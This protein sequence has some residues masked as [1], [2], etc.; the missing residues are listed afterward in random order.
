MQKIPNMMD[1]LIGRDGFHLLQG[2]CAEHGESRYPAMERIKQWK[3]PECAIRETQKQEAEEQR[4]ARISSLLKISN[5][6]ER[7]RATRFEC[8]T[9]RQKQAKAG[10]KIFFDAVVSGE[11]KWRVLL[12]LGEAGTGKT[13]LASSIGENVVQMTA[14]QVRYTTAME[15]MADIRETYSQIDKSEREVIDRFGS[16]PL[17]IIDEID[18]LRE[19]D[20]R[21]MGEIINK[22]YNHMLPT[23]A[24]SNRN[25]QD[26]KIILGDRVDSRFDENCHMIIFDWESFRK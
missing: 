26:L 23:I 8:H 5:I 7:Y 2:T 9:E 25:R 19:S 20:I 12:L 13:L 3:C 6:P 11:R 10:A 17:L 16:Y 18:Q 24:V 1:E 22:R 15:M 21:L 14:K 4:A